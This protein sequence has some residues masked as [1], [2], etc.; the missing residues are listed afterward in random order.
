VEDDLLK[1]I[2]AAQARAAHHLLILHGRYTCT[3]R[4]PRCGQCPL[5]DLCPW[6]G[7]TI[8]SPAVQ[9]VGTSMAQTPSP[10]QES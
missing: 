3:A 8:S 5:A 1:I 7:K 6:P 10:P 4:A 9:P 2:P